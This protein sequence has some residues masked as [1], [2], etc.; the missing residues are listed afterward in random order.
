MTSIRIEHAPRLSRRQRAARVFSQLGRYALGWGL[1]GW[2]CFWMGD[3]HLLVPG[4]IFAAMVCNPWR[5]KRP[6][7]PV[8]RAPRRVGDSLLRTR[9]AVVR[10]GLPSVVPPRA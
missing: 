1:T 10:A 2:A 5:P 7:R 8:R 3:V 6:E 4:L 9:R